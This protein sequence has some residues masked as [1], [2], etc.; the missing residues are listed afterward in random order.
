MTMHDHTGRL[1][2]SLE[3]S[4]V[5]DFPDGFDWPHPLDQIAGEYAAA[6]SAWIAADVDR[7]GAVASLADARETD[8]QALIEAAVGR[9]GD[10]GTPHENA[11]RRAVIYAEEVTRQAA[12]PVDTLAAAFTKAVSEQRED[13]MRQAI[14]LEHEAIAQYAALMEHARQLADQAHIVGK[15][16]GSR[17]NWLTT[18]LDDPYPMIVPASDR[19]VDWPQQWHIDSVAAGQVL[20]RLAAALDP[21][22]V[23]DVEPTADDDDATSR[24]RRRATPSPRA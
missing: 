9:T 6:L 5:L 18:L 21:A 17:V 10:P 22:A 12:R 4:D 7:A 3:P 14:A 23:L 13:V 24:I 2:S 16:I 11:A 20:E 15:A 1:D 19:G 8:R